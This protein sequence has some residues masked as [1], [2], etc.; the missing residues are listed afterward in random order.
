MGAK[1]VSRFVEQASHPCEKG[2]RLE[3]PACGPVGDAWRPCPA[4]SRAGAWP[5]LSGV[6]GVSWFA[7]WRKRKHVRSES[8]VVCFPLLIQCYLRPVRSAV[9]RDPVAADRDVKVHT[10][11]TGRACRRIILKPMPCYSA[12]RRVTGRARRSAARARGQ[13]CSDGLTAGRGMEGLLR[14]TMVGPTWTPTHG[15]REA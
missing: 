9:R 5:G 1:P 12:G 4:R 14:S 15:T 3:Q 7:S 11:L 6:L 13:K 2:V 10:D 8:A